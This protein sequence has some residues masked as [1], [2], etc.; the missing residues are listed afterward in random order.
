MSNQMISFERKWVTS[1]SSQVETSTQAAFRNQPKNFQPNNYP[2]KAILSRD[3]CNFCEDNH[4][5]STY[6]VKKN[7]RERIFG[8]KVD[9]IIV[10]LYWDLEEDVMMVDTRN[11]SY[12]NKGKGGPS[13]TTFSPSSSS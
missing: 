2:P 7:A 10:A 1:T 8:K 6:E 3:W 11:K 12:E 5:E 4:D 13:K 9:T